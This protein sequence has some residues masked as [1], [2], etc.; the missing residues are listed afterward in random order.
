MKIPKFTL[1][2]FLLNQPNILTRIKKKRILIIKIN[3][4]IVK[5]V[6]CAGNIL[7]SSFKWTYSRICKCELAKRRRNDK[8]VYILYFFI[9]RNYYDCVIFVFFLV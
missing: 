9:L 7:A 2:T 6:F 3:V 5:E 1:F 4:P 8:Y